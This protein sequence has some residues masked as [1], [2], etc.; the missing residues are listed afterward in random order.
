MASFIRPCIAAT[1]LILLLALSGH[2]AEKA[3]GGDWRTSLETIRAG[4]DRITSV[5]ASF[6]QEKHMKILIKPLVSKGDFYFRKPG[7][8]RWEY[9][10]PVRSVLIFH[11][12][13]TRYF[14]MGANGLTESAGSG[15][16]AMQVG[17]Q[18][19]TRWMSG[20][21]DENPAFAMALLPGGKIVL[22]AKDPSIGRFVQKIEIRLAKQPGGVE[23]ASIFESQDSYTRLNFENS[24]FNETLK[25]DVF[26]DV[27]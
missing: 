4:I 12:A 14:A 11:N 6:V 7:S 25:P 13:K 24:T 26:T 18:E 19:I 2:A 10:T 5:K 21:F 8:L 20:R 9:K 16:Q 15:V 22:T 23:S 1:T 17:L 3:P 27:R